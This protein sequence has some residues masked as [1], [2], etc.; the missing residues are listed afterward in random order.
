MKYK[1]DTGFPV[2]KH[3][4]WCEN[5][6]KGLEFNTSFALG[7]ICFAIYQHKTIPGGNQSLFFGILFFNIKEILKLIN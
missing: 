2:N 7:Q 1:L 4:P 3:L 6:I 5:R